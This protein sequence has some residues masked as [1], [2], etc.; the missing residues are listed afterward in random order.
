MGCFGKDLKRHCPKGERRPADVIGAGVKVMRIATDE[1]DEDRAAREVG[2]DPA[3]VVLGK[4]GKRP[5]RQPQQ[6]AARRSRPKAAK[7]QWK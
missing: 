2:K 6:D 4:R 3:T 1:L 7:S 5:R